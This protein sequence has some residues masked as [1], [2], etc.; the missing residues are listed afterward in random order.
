MS[1]TYIAAS[2]ILALNFDRFKCLA[3]SLGM[4]G[5]YAGMVV[6]PVVS[7]MLLDE[8]G[9]SKAMGIMGSFHASHIVLGL[10]FFQASDED[11][12]NGMSFICKNLNL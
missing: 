3:F 7:Q 6:F 12:S 1:N 10:L 2:E 9:Y 4:L 11:E 5:C 8:F